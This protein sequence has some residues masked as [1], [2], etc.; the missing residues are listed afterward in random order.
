MLIR[1]HLQI[2]RAL[3]L[4]FFHKRHRHLSVDQFL[5]LFLKILT[6]FSLF[7]VSE[8]S[9]HN[10]GANNETHSVPKKTVL[11]F[12]RYIPLLCLKLHG[13][14]IK[15][16]KSDIFSGEVIYFASYISAARIWRFFWRM[17]A[18]L[19]FGSKS[20]KDKSCEAS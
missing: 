3:R 18:L 4:H 10:F 17:L 5:V 13:F 2:K 20:L 7:H 19:S 15:R 14:C 9:S 1:E 8:R 11:S 6:E 12:L 16:N